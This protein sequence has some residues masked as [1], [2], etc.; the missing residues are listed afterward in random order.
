MCVCVV[1]DCLYGDASSDYVCSSKKN[2][3][4]VPQWSLENISLLS[5]CGGN[6]RLPRWGASWICMVTIVAE[7][8]RARRSGQKSMN[9]SWVWTILGEN[10][11]PPGSVLCRF[12][13]YRQ[14][15]I[16]T[17]LVRPPD[18]TCSSQH[19]RYAGGIVMIITTVLDGTTKEH[20]YTN[21]SQSQEQKIQYKDPNNN[22]SELVSGY[23]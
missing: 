18:I 5:W 7:L 11:T 21:D 15:R 6:F 20:I 8:E 23:G 10:V 14:I 16:T 2:C 19:T 17:I 12:K 9:V 13:R 3:L 4:G 22:R 1:Y